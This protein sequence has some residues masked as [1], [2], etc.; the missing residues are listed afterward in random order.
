MSYSQE[1]K[2]LWRWIAVIAVLG[3]LAAAALSV[4]FVRAREDAR[5]RRVVAANERAAVL[6]VDGVAA[7]QQLHLEARGEYGTFPQLVEAG[8]FR[9]PALDGERL[10]AEGY[11][12]DLRV[13]PRAE[14]RPPAFALH[15]D[16]V[17]DR[18]PDATGRRHFYAGSDVTGIRFHDERPATAA[19]PPL[20]RANDF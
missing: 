2:R 17:R 3:V 8:V 19:D 18:G 6:V 15:A 7:A 16:P 13:T 20:S 14:A 12:F 10:V 9:A 4:Y 1:T 11:S 5:R